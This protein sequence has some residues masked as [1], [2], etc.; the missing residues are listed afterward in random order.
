VSGAALRSLS[1]DPIRREVPGDRVSVFAVNSAAF[2]Q[3]D[4]ARLVDALRDGGFS[5]ISLVAEIDGRLVGHILFSEMS[6]VGTDGTI[7]A[8]ALAPMAVVPEFQRHGIGSALVRRGLE[9]CR[10]L[11]HRAVIVLGHP[12][13]YPR[14]GFSA[15]AAVRIE[16]PFSGEA[17]MALKL[18]TATDWELAGKAV[19]A[20]PFG[21]S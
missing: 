17:F 14:F 8:L 12:H 20:P 7:A 1:D 15:A 13:Y 4:E 18:D 2:G 19:Y 16:A 21:I 9:L 5:R 10:E 3:E 11:P 6:V